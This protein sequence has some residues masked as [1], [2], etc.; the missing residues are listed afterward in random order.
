MSLR[1]KVLRFVEIVL[2]VPPLFVIDEILKVGIG[3]PP[4][5]TE[6]ELAK[7]ESFGSLSGDHNSTTYLQYDRT[8]Y[9]LLLTALMRMLLCA[10]GKLVMLK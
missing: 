8:F 3:D 1:T 2:R 9:K 4:E 6:E 7:Y 5:F 10:V